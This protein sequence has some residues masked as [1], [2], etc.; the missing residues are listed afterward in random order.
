MRVETERMYL[1]PLS[2]EEMRLVIENESDSEMKQAYTEMLEGSLSNSDKRIWYAIWNM[3]LK[4]ESGI[5]VGD[6]CFKGLSDDEVIEI[7]YGL[8]EEYRHHGYM[9][10]AVKVITEWAL[11][12][13]GVKQVEAET[14]AENIASQK[15][16]FR[17]GFIRNGKMGEEGPRFV[18][19]DR[20]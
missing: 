6:F 16:L 7:G 12:Q 1:Y 14:D 18:Y 2:D 10:E 4:D 5:I 3:E 9:M 20:I 17:T 8:K 15:V 13:E 11:S 19:G